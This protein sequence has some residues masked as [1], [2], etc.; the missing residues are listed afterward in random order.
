MADTGRCENSG[1]D[2]DYL[3]GCANVVQSKEDFGVKV[4]EDPNNISDLSCD[5]NVR[6]LACEKAIRYIW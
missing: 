5:N 6:V 1:N 2:L 3:K 4:Y